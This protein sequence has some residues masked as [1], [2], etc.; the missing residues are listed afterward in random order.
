MTPTTVLMVFSGTSLSWRATS[1]PTMAT[2]TAA[3]AAASA[4]RPRRCWAAPRLTTISTTSVP[5]RKTPLKATANPTPSC[6][7]VPGRGAGAARRVLRR[8]DAQLGHRGRKDLVLV[9]RILVA[10]RPQDRLAEPGQAE[11]QEQRSHHHAQRVDRDVADERDADG[12]HQD[13]EH[14]QRGRG[15]LECRTPAAAHA[16][17][18]HDGQGLDH[19]HQAGGE[20][21]HDEDEGR[22]GVH[23]PAQTT[24]R[25]HAGPG[26]GGRL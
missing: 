20:H 13:A 21:R 26:P 4:A 25:G 15:P 11:H 1:R 24:R 8:S 3:A 7:G 6:F 12:E 2:R 14:R 10:A 17:R 5:S 19:L 23:L 18:H 16:G 9:M 22:R